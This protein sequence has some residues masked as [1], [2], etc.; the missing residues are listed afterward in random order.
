MAERG[1]MA[2]YEDWREPVRQLELDSG[3]ATEA[4]RALAEHVDLALGGSEPQGVAAVMLEQHLRPAIW[5]WPPTLQPT[6]SVPSSRNSVR[7]QRAS[8]H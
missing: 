5:G 6:G 7:Q 1:E 2:T 8:H 3:P 4:Q